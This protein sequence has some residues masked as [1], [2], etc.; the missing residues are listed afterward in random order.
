MPEGMKVRTACL[1]DTRLRHER[2]R[3]PTALQAPR[4]SVHA[5]YLHTWRKLHYNYHRDVGERSSSSFI[6]PSSR[7]AKMLDHQDLPSDRADERLVCSAA[8]PSV[9]GCSAGSFNA[10]PERTSC[11]IMPLLPSSDRLLGPRPPVSDPLPSSSSPVLISLDIASC[12]SLLLLTLLPLPM[13]L[14]A[15]EPAWPVTGDISC[16]D[17]NMKPGLAAPRPIAKPAA[18]G[19]SLCR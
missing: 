2:V 9:D 7:L 10:S 17:R 12:P 8:S 4:A 19:I 3:G 5:S 11:R 13:P 6:R 14:S 1:P 18:A 16:S 15:A